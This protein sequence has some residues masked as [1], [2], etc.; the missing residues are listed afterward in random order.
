MTKCFCILSHFL[1]H[2]GPTMSSSMWRVFRKVVQPVLPFHYVPFCC[3]LSLM[4]RGSGRKGYPARYSLFL[5]KYFLTVTY[6][7]CH[8]MSDLFCLVLYIKKRRHSRM[9]ETWK[10][11]PRAKMFSF[12]VKTEDDSDYRINNFCRLNCLSWILPAET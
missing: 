7:F 12:M 8:I 11:K 10:A 4:G 3:C 2:I 5:F 9:Y 1:P 6:S